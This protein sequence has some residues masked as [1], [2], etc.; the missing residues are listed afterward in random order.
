[1]KI[2]ALERKNLGN[3]IDFTRFS[4]FGEFVE[5]ELTKTEEI[6]ERSKDAQVLIIN[7]LPMNESTLGNLKQ[8]QLICVTATGTDNVDLNYCKE[9]QIAVCNA[10]GYSTDSVVQHTFAM[11][12][13][14]LE[15][16]PYYDR[17]T[18][19][20]D[21]IKSDIFTHFD[22]YF[23]EISHKTWG[24]VGMGDIGKKVAGVAKAFGCDVIYYSTT[25]KNKVDGVERVEWDALLE[26]SDVISIHA[27]LNERTENLF[28]LQAFQKMK[29]STYL[30]NVGRGP[31]VNEE[32][33]SIALRENMIAGAAL[34][35]LSKEPMKAD[36]PLLKLKDYDNLFITPH[37]AWA[38]TEAR[39][40]LAGEV[41][42]NIESYLN[43]GNYGRLC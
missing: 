24:I 42:K 1:M 35:V 38:T 34:D 14:L 5:Y 10:K 41:L 8:L 40:R 7:K 32:D 39:N 17:Y 36:N 16:L 13:Y 6:F 18:K 28:D 22:Q 21:Y 26:R 29:K 4:Q 2:V 43:G 25:G 11:Y 23:T 3:D 27:P 33:L 30:I 19:S 9:H 37:I 20:G 12:F 31:I 15:H